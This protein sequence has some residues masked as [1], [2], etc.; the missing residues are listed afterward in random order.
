MTI[1]TSE[2]H[3][4]YINGYLP[5]HTTDEDSDCGLVADLRQ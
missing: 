3:T 1:I 2:I 5:Q 4:I